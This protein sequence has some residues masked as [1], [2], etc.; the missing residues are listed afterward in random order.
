MTELKLFGVNATVAFC[1]GEVVGPMRHDRI[2]LT[3][4]KFSLMAPGF[5]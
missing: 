2:F 4:I 1:P 5:F 3:G